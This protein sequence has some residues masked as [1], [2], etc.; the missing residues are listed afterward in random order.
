MRI[1]FLLY[2]F[3][4][5][6]ILRSQESEL[7]F[8]RI[9]HP[10]MPPI[11]SE[12]FFFS[13]DGLM[14]FSTGQGLTSFDG[15]DV[16]YHSSLRQSNS[17]GLSKVSAMAEDKEHNFYIATPGGLYYFDR[18][19]KSYNEIQYRYKD[20][21]K[22]F[23]P[24]FVAL[25]YDNTGV[26]Y[27]GSANG[28]LIVYDPFKKEL[29]HHNLDS[30][31]ADSWEDRTFNTVRSF[32]SHANDSNKLWVGTFH[33]IYLFAKKE[34]KFSQHFEIISDITH[35]FNPTFKDKRSIDAHRMNVANDSLIWFNSWAGGF[36]KYNTQ[37]GKATIVFGRD[38]LYKAKDL[39]YGYIIPGFTRLSEGK[40]L[41][42]IYSGKTA[43]YNTHT[44]ET[45]Y[46]NVTEN[47]YTEEETRYVDKDRKGNIWLLQRGFLYATVPA[48]RRLRTIKIPG[49]RPF[50]LNRPKIRG[51]YFDS[52]SR[53]FYCGFL[54]SSGIHVY[55]TNFVQQNIIP[56][57]LINN[58]YNFGSTIDSKITK[59]GSSRFWVIG[60]K[61]HI[62]LPGEKKFK[63]VENKFPS[64]K[65]L[66]NENHFNDITATRN[67]NILIRG[68]NGNIYHINHVTLATDTI[69]SPDIKTD[70]VEIQPASA[71]YDDKSDFIYL[72]RKEGIAQFN[73]E[74]KQMRVFTYASLFGGLSS[75]QGACSPALDTGKRIWFMIP[76]YG[77]RIIDPVSLSCVDSI[78]FGEK[79]LMR[80]DYTTIVGGAGNYMLFRSQNGIV[81]YDYKKKQSFLFDHSNGLSSPDNKSF[82]YSNGYVFI[83]QGSSRFEYF[84]L[85]D[86]DN[87]TPAVTPY[88][89]S[90]T[91]DTINVFT[92]TGLEKDQTIRLKY[93]Q[94]T[95]T[96][97]FSAPEFFF[98]ERIEYAYQLAP[99][100]K[101]WHYTDYFERKI[102]Y[103]KLSPGEYVFRLKSQMQGSNWETSPVEYIIIVAPAWWQTNLFKILCVF[104]AIALI[105]YLYRRRIIAIRNKEQQRTQHEKELLELEAKA[106]RAQMNPHFVFNSLNSIKSLINKNENDKAATYLTTFSKLIRTLFQN[107]DKR[108]VSLFEELETCK[109]YTQLEKMR[110]GDKVNFIFDI[111][112]SIDLKD[113][114]IP[115]LI[116]QPFIENAIW[117][118]IM[119]KE[120]GG[121]VTVSVKQKNGAIECVIDDDGI[122][123]EMSKKYKADY[124]STHQSRGIGLTQLRLELDKLINER[125]DIIEI[126]DK[127][128]DLSLSNGT[129]VVINFKERN[130][131]TVKKG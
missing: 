120:S 52:A 63:P 123:R 103:S 87:Y 66:G 17:L 92:R 2:G 105:I 126:I 30:T 89:N 81:V 57:S 122:G 129:R 39:Y 40:Y 62:L 86:L 31:K 113:V 51:V 33:G 64:L 20:N 69:R 32:A 131:V 22:P 109:L 110:F 107:S 88:L 128:K 115:A 12:Y 4:F 114:K 102:I 28:G 101:E 111:D 83:G 84:K 130:Q 98:P 79:G 27:A 18:V 70:G 61:N 74:K 68:I 90:I 14:W 127:K 82:L 119:P 55:D 112:G 121:N 117:H 53:L 100:E 46:F 5:A 116:I 35:R 118:G 34:K 47:D 125:E 73:L 56:T 106:L 38:A 7:Q 15:S 85:S 94:N 37:T 24:G 67:G 91:A 77:I 3:L 65:W 75:F 50:H 43:I 44:D 54:G 78:Q 8:K 26:I 72:V 23:T 6:G 9:T 80:G 21:Q 76:K 48:N 95:L 36:A 59:D 93:F 42:G 124:E 99:L 58:Y 11:T 1:F 108:E 29:S 10:F 45:V 49:L 104:T 71:W 96:F 25:H 97:S 41:L 13:E 60:W 16:V 19:K